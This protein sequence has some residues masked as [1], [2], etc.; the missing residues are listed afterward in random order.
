MDFQRGREQESECCFIG[1]IIN[2]H[3]ITKK[4]LFVVLDSTL[5]SKIL[6]DSTRVLL[7]LPGLIKINSDS[8]YPSNRLKTELV[9]QIVTQFPKLR[10]TISGNGYEHFYDSK[11]NQGFIE[12]RLKTMRKRLCPSK[13][14]RTVSKE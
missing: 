6:N 11:T 14:R 12:F 4:F 10:S 8:L 2:I 7:T 3:G 9:S 1:Y 13:K 5:F